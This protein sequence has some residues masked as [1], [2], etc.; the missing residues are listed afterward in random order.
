MSDLI[1]EIEIK[2]KSKITNIIDSTNE[3]LFETFEYRKL[4]EDNDYVFSEENSDEDKE[5]NGTNV[6]WY[7]NFKL[8]K[9]GLKSL[10]TIRGSAIAEYSYGRWTENSCYSIDEVEVEILK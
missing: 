10:V 9:N 3:Y 2:E 4:F 5:E 6:T 8:E 7:I 1:S